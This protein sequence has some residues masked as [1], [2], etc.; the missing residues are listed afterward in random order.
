MNVI[1]SLTVVV[2]L[3][4]LAAIC[5]MYISYCVDRHY[6][7]NLGRKHVVIAVCFVC[8]LVFALICFGDYV[9]PFERKVEPVLI[10][11]FNV[12]EEYEL[13][14]P[15]QK[16]W[17]GAYGAYG[18]YAESFYFN[19]NNSNSI[20]GFGWPPMDFNRYCY[21]I[22]YGQRIQSLTYNVWETIEEP[23]RTGAK[24]GHMI[25]CD[26]FSPEKVYVYRIPKVRI[27]NDINDINSRWD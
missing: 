27:E 21:I 7:K 23:I 3:L 13:K 16:F 15:G 26:E 9:Y 6:T 14:Y 12:P 25:L 10:A 20:Y 11:E 22:T 2:C 5:V 1:K 17:H 4:S 24:V 8:V 18:L 19:P